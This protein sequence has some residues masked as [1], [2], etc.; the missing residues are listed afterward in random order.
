MARFHDPEHGGFFTTAHDAEQLVV[1]AKDLFDNA[2]PSAG[3][4]AAD[5]LLRLG[6]L[7][8]ERRWEEP[9]LGV[10]RLVRRGLEQAPSALAHALVA[11]DR[12]VH[13]PLE[14]AVVGDPGAPGTAALLVAVWGRELPGAVRLGARPG[15]GAE[16][17]PLLADRGLVDGLPTAYVCSGFACERPV[18]DARALTAQLD[19]SLTHGRADAAS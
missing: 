16:R 7:T 18:T 15:T 2:T 19:A 1:R 11:V 17:T 3:S 6:A 5:G 4:L 10:L 12:V 9:A 13:P 8:G 14:V